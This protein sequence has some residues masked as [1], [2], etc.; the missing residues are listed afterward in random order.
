MEELIVSKDELVTMFAE[1]KITDSDIGWLYNNEVIV[2]IVA[3]HDKDP[4][5][6]YDITNAQYYKIVPIKNV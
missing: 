1:E 2:N 3:L 5:Y 4:K 6:I